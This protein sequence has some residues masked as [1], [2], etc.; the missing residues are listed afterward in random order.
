MSE[1]STCIGCIH[2]EWGRT[3][4]GKLHPSGDGNCLYLKKNPMDLRIPAA[5]YWTTGRPSPA[6]GWINRKANYGIANGCAFKSEKAN[7]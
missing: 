3:A 7:P 5:F 2:A 4:N 1:N 6:G